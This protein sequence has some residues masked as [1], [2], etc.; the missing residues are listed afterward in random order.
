M[1][2]ISIKVLRAI[3]VGAA[4]A[5]VAATAASAAYTPTPITVPLSQ[6]LGAT[7]PLAAANTAAVAQSATLVIDRTITLTQNETVTAP[8]YGNGSGII[9][10]ASYTLITGVFAGVPG[11]QIVDVGT[12]NISI[13]DGVW[14]DAS[15]LIPP[16]Y[17]SG[18]DYQPGLQ[19]AFNIVFRPQ[20][21]P[22]GGP[23]HLE[24]DC[25]AAAN[26][27][28]PGV[29]LNSGISLVD[30]AHAAFHSDCSWQMQANNTSFFNLNLINS[31][32]ATSWSFTGAMS[33]GWANNQ[34]CT[35]P[36]STN[37]N[38][39]MLDA[40]YVAGSS[41]YHDFLIDGPIAVG[42]GGCGFMQT[43]NA[44]SYYNG[45][46]A[47]TISNIFG[48]DLYGAM[49][50]SHPQ[51]SGGSE[52]QTYF[53]INEQFPRGSFSMFD[54]FA[55]TA[56]SINSISAD[57]FGIYNGPFANSIIHCEQCF[58]GKITQAH[59]EENTISGSGGF[60]QVIDLTNSTSFTVDGV[61]YF[62]NT[63]AAGNFIGLVGGSVNA[64]VLIDDVWTST[65]T[66]GSG[67]QMILVEPRQTTTQF[68]VGRRISLDS[69]FTDVTNP[70][71]FPENA[72]LDGQIMQA[73]YC[74]ATSTDTSETDCLISASGTLGL[75][76]PRQALVR[77]YTYKISAAITGGSLKIALRDGAGAQVA[78]TTLT[79]ASALTGSV[80]L[81]TIPTATLALAQGDTLRVTATATSLLPTGITLT[82]TPVY[83]LN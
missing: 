65:T 37:S 63:I 10:L 11:K 80:I 9:H 35:Y 70:S 20:N 26:G 42:G 29:Y 56:L 40:Q 27:N 36:S 50:Y 66:V 83:R 74:N 1:L 28:N 19:Q 44:H 69:G 30:F 48:S 18:V 77:E 64:S 60:G 24:L 39:F 16:L 7:D 76:M 53:N 34:T 33:F 15:W 81:T 38:V 4:T 58:A 31:A 49:F 32:D 79:S 41:G 54:L 13:R 62:N 17:N 61:V 2:G 51:V 14:L 12:G 5:I 8:I 78:T 43:S 82:I 52:R 6:Y 25:G 47:F 55:V 75:Q 71:L 46:W 59:I 57:A 22:V 3:L 23:K 72:L 68:T 45:A 21:G 67:G 73:F